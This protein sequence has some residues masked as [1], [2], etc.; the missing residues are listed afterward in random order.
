MIA[1]EFNRLI[2]HTELRFID[3]CCHAPMME[4]PNLF[5]EIV[6]QFLSRKA[7]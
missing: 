7:A 5:N 3:K 4:H 1:Y 6:D 2:P